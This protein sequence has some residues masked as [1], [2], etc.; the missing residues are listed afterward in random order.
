MNQSFEFY[1]QQP[2]EGGEY[3]KELPTFIS[4]LFVDKAIECANR[5]F[6]PAKYRFSKGRLIDVKEKHSNY[7]IMINS[8]KPISHQMAEQ[9]AAWIE[10]YIAGWL[11]GEQA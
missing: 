10:G 9:A 4:Y 2:D 3:S 11:E 8:F 6:A 1:N 7:T 5:C